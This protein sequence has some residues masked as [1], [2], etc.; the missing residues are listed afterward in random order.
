MT[1]RF[2]SGD[3]EEGGRVDAA[4]GRAQVA[5]PAHTN[6][7][8]KHRRRRGGRT[9]VRESES[10]VRSRSKCSTGFRTFRPGLRSGGLGSP[11][12]YKLQTGL[13]KARFGAAIEISSR[14]DG[15]FI[16]CLDCR[17]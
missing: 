9:I 5:D 1:R 7:E 13:F 17:P 3:S 12:M 10:S 11:K 8:V 14:S 2:I 15:L 6:V 16:F 4:C